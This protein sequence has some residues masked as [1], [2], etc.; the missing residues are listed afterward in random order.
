MN[1]Y[2]SPG[3]YCAVSAFEHPRAIELAVA[4]HWY[5][6]AELLTSRRS[7]A[8][9][10]PMEFLVINIQSE[11]A[12]DTVN[13]I[14]DPETIM[15]CVAAK[16][17]RCPEVLAM[18]Q[19][20]PTV[21][22]LNLTSVNEPKS[23]CL[24]DMPWEDK[25]LSWT[26]PEF[27]SDISHWLQRTAIAELHAF[28]QPL[29]PFLLGSGWGVVLPHDFFTEA[30][31]SSL[32][33]VSECD[34]ESNGLKVLR[35][36]LADPD[37]AREQST[38]ACVFCFGEP[39]KHGVI[40]AL[41]R[42][43]A[44]LAALLMTAGIDL[45]DQL[46]AQLQTSA[47]S[48]DLPKSGV[49]VFVQL[50]RLRDKDTPPVAETWVF[51]LSSVVGALESTGH[52][53]RVPDERLVVPLV[54]P[55]DVPGVAETVQVE[56][57]RPMFEPSRESAQI[58]SG[59]TDEVTL[60]QVT[61]I[62]AGALGSQI[63]SNLSKMGWGQWSVIDDDLLMPHN[64]VRHRLGNDAI[65]FSKANALATV[66]Q[67][68]TPFNPVKRAL[69]SDVLK[70]LS[71]G[72]EYSILGEADLLLDVSTSIAVARFLA[73]DCASTARRVSVFLNPTGN[74]AVLLSEDAVRTTKLDALEA[75]YY[76]A[77]RNSQDLISHLARADTSRYGGG[78]RDV[79]VRIGQD[80]VATFSGLLAKQI[81][82]ID[83]SASIRIWRSRTD[84]GID[85]I[86]VPVEPVNE[87]QNNDWT[88]VIDEGV[89][90]IMRQ[91]RSTVLPNETGGVLVGMVDQLRKR[92]YIADALPAPRDSVEFPTSFIRGCADLPG[93]LE[94]V[95]DESGGQLRYVGEWHSHPPG[96]GIAKSGA[97]MKLLSELTNEVKASGLPGLM[98]IVEDVDYGIYCQTE[99]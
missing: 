37:E 76:R 71:D 65:G 81:R 59:L 12:Q 23:L 5:P 33:R 6:F 98:V 75:Q 78:C 9:G 69:H 20:F 56:A 39:T 16:D 72:P 93:T 1:Y 57:V 41:P 77:V 4:I 61:L 66:V 13:D 86:I 50:P 21:P 90:K 2:E 49:M 26:A 87:Y 18:R 73:L 36:W 91:Y 10:Q 46:K 63:H 3:E 14:R 94:Q 64:L 11:I 74:D 62:G 15:I 68:E 28:D 44:D 40:N 97:D 83:F 99:S 45:L 58:Y 31:P 85:A 96:A 60:T 47:Q 95:F 35:A 8:D 67:H 43:L 24:Y 38:W 34:S 29:E 7:V 89:V 17:D 92:I 80:D 42:N 51:F 84:G 53:G 22:H 54:V 70:V 27:L 19:T 32:V 48:G 25:R 30:K 52:F 82:Q 55:Q 88:T 79:S